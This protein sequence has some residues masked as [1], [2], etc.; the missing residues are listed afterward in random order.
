MYAFDRDFLFLLRSFFRLNICLCHM[1]SY[2]VFPLKYLAIGFTNFT[3]LNI[4]YDCKRFGL[5]AP[6]VLYIH[7]NSAN[8]S[9]GPIYT[10]KMCIRLR[11][12]IHSMSIYFKLE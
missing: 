9:Y 3:N 12:H 2:L 11:G 7:V 10:Y 5:E 8:L 4:I 1:F 6:P